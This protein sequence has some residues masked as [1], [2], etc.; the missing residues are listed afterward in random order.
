MTVF[1]PA[2]STTAVASTGTTHG[3]GLMSNSAMNNIGVVPQNSPNTNQPPW[4]AAPL[5]S[6]G[7]SDGTD[8]F[9]TG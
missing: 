6:T 7:G 5:I 1:V 3:A 9:T 2:P 4:V 8:V